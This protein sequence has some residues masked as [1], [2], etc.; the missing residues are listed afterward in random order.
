MTAPANPSSH[1]IYPII[2][3]GGSGSRLWPLSRIQ[4]PKQLLRLT[5]SRTMLQETVL[6]LSGG[7]SMAPPIVISNE[8]H[9]FI[10]A[11]QL[12]ELDI[13][14]TA[15]LL[16]PV[17]RN[18]AAAA[19]VA[20]RLVA[21]LRSDG[22]LL[23]APSDH[24]MADVDAFREKIAAGVHH[25]AN[26]KIVTF[27]IR[28]SSP[29][30]GYGYVGRGEP[31]GDDAFTVAEFVEKPDLV[32][33]EGFFASGTY[34]WNSGIFLCRA[35]VLMREMERFCPEILQCC[36]EALVHGSADLDFVRLDRSAFE[37]CPSLPI[38]T[39]VME[40]TRQAVVLPM[41]IGWSDVGSWNALWELGEKDPDG[42]VMLGDVIALD[43]HDCYLR[44]EHHLLATLGVD[45][46][47]VV[48]SG[49]AVVVA[50][51]DHTSGVGELVAR[52]KELGRTEHDA[53]KRVHRP[54]GFYESVQAGERF[55]VKH[56]LVNPGA[57]LSQQ[58][59][60]HRA[61]HWVVVR[62]T[63]MVTIGDKTMLVTENEST[64]I[65]IGS[66]HKL[67]NPGKVPLSIIEVQSGAYLGE[68]DITRFADRYG[69]TDRDSGV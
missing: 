60:H 22:I 17:G 42:N 13:R 41:N 40:H 29:A 8:I 69:R 10:I 62:G 43:S 30:I 45:G 52:L 33:A 1:R 48:D 11:A 35:D 4:M 47:I 5:S 27:G 20:A 25:A 56:L 57:A 37:S 64:F 59:H 53:H 2:L 54:W 61:E 23:I 34:Y 68:D 66:V 26:G 14:P 39:A 65:P 67:E 50:H 28:P 21:S 3:S 15:H 31:L 46:L 16:E 18:T 9:R 55:Q 63:A 51:K 49:D 36:T 24:H 44:S 6:R 12:Q 58:M 32:R 7:A 19:A 38:D